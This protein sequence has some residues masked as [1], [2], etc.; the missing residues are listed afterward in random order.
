MESF[1]TDL[2]AATPPAPNRQT[3][4]LVGVEEPS[5]GTC[6]RITL[7]NGDELA[8]YNVNGEYYATDNSCPHRSAPLSEGMVCGHIV[9]CALHGWQFD[10]RTGECLTVSDKI[11][12]YRVMKEDGTVSIELD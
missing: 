6:A 7:H 11:R 9:E 3:F 1:D 8:I 10:V 12:T 2:D 4:T 5:P